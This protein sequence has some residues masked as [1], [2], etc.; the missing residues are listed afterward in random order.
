MVK[1][2]ESSTCFGCLL[3]V[4]LDPAPPGSIDVGTYKAIL[5]LALMCLFISAGSYCEFSSC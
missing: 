3:N 1:T 5:F 4:L 2:K